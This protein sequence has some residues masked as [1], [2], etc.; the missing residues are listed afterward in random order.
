MDRSG[1]DAPCAVP[2]MFR[3]Y[4][5]KTYTETSAAIPAI[6]HPIPIPIL[7]PVPRPDDKAAFEAESAA[8]SA[9]LDEELIGADATTET[10]VLAGVVEAAE[11]VLVEEL[12][13]EGLELDELELDELELDEL[14]LDELEME[15]PVDFMR[16]AREK[17]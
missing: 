13:L 3:L 9:E 14:E 7:A 5:P 1:C 16:T 2:D 15:P 11:G 6:P 10:E 4:R 12:E 8:P 17:S